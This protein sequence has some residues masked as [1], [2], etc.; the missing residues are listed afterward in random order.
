M[1]A[2]QGFGR[3]PAGD[4]PVTIRQVQRVIDK[5]GHF[6]IDTVNVAV[7]AHYMP[8][9]A[10]LGPYDRG[11]LER[12]AGV[13]PRRLFECWLGGAVSYLDVELYP[14]FRHRMAEQQA[15]PWEWLARIS[16]EHPELLGKIQRQL[17]E[18][19][20]LTARQIEH[21]DN[22]EPGA[23][24]NW[25]DAKTGLEWL[26][27]IGEVTV[28]SRN[29]QFERLYNLPERV[30]PPAILA[31]GDL[32]AAEATRLLVARSAAAL[33]VATER[34]LAGYFRLNAARAREAVADLVASGELEPVA[35]K[36]WKLPAYLWHE[37]RLPRRLAGDSL[38]SPFDSLVSDR[39]RLLQTFG[40]DYR[41]EIYVPAAK[42]VWGYYVYLFVI[43]DAI[44][45][46][47]DLKA[48]RQAGALLVQAA[49]L[50]PGAPS[51]ETAGRL[52]GALR[53]MAGW[54]GLAGVEVRP[55]GTLAAA[56]ER[57]V[58]AATG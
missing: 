15:R 11:L 33:A 18:H 16:A 4:G 37:A 23:W 6:Q 27:T 36:G 56:L 34:D 21:P 41:I 43:D 44:T 31:R 49:W 2:A 1:L 58:R 5:V 30:I 42:R 51:P 46:R 48:D 3:S 52:A 24:W 20:P 26:L 50:E 28:A 19:G 55:K 38:V 12:A 45:A 54:L 9:F 47:V 8:L 14:A 39:D 57:E 53:S 25:S 10:R 35:V 13:A 7:R 32:E 17:S 29:P 22:R 40:V